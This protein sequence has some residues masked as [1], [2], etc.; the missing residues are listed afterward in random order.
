MQEWMPDMY[1]ETTKRK[2]ENKKAGDGGWE[3]RDGGEW[4]GGRGWRGD[5]AGLGT[6]SRHAAKTKCPCTRIAPG[7]ECSLCAWRDYNYFSSASERLAGR[8]RCGAFQA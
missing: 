7:I 2:Q 5:G 3:E 1:K 8:N 6:Q 4:V